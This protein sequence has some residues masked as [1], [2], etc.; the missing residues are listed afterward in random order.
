M[1]IFKRKKDRKGQGAVEFALMLPVLMLLILGLIEFGRLIFLYI[2]VNSAGREAARYGM[3]MGDGPSG[4][5][6]Y[7]DCDGI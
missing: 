7:Y 2:T 5:P 1:K 3:A 6:Q 4:V